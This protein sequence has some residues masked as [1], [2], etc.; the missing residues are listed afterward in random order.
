MNT[1]KKS[2]VTVQ[3]FCFL[4]KNNIFQ[5]TFI[6][7]NFIILKVNYN[8]HLLSFII[9]FFCFKKIIYYIYRGPPLINLNFKKIEIDWRN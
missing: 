6:V 9:D 8:S 2:T 1:C 4:K 3:N 7:Q 5:R